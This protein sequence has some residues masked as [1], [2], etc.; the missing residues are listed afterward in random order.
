MSAFLLYD[1]IAFLTTRYSQGEYNVFQNVKGQWG[2]EPN[3][4]PLRNWTDL[5]KPLYK[6]ELISK[7]TVILNTSSVKI[8]PC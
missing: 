1:T 3:A 6:K 4:A 2:F 7:Y 8:K 5:R